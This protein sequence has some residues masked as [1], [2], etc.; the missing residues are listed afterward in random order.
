MEE[1]KNFKEFKEIENLGQ[2]KKIEK[3]KE[4][5]EKWIKYNNNIK[6]LQKAIKDQNKLKNE[7][8]PKI[9]E[10]MET[11]NIQDLTTKDGKIKYEVSNRKAPL[12][13]KNI[14]KQLVKYFQ[15]ENDANNVVNYL[16]DNREVIVSSKVRIVN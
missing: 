1:Q 13:K 10:Y 6:K 15:N 9:K 3:L 5:V 11:N 2:N 14:Q 4:M 12:N 8:Y 7:I 16:M